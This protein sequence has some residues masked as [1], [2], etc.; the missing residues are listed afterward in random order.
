MRKRKDEQ[1]LTGSK[2]GLSRQEKKQKKLQDR[3]EQMRIKAL[4]NAY[5][6]GLKVQNKTHQLVRINGQTLE[7]VKA[8]LDAARDS[9]RDSGPAGGAH[10]GSEGASTPSG[11]CDDPQSTGRDYSPPPDDDTA[12]GAF[13]PMAAQSQPTRQCASD[14]Q[15]N[16][17]S[18]EEDE[19]SGDS[20]GEDDACPEM[21]SIGVSAYGVN[22]DDYAQMVRMTNDSQCDGSMFLTHAVED[23]TTSAIMCMPGRHM[24][25][26]GKL[27]WGVIYH[28]GFI[29]LPS[30]PDSTPVYF[31]D[32][33][34]KCIRA[35]M[36]AE[37]FLGYTTVTD[38][39]NPLRDGQVDSGSCE[40]ID[41]LQGIVKHSGMTATV[42]A[43]SV[44]Q[45]CK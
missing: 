43:E 20:S 25:K 38:Q 26:E 42:F 16:S 9:N 2:P 17:E 33:C 39:F 11:A 40:H 21:H 5:N 19:D 28:P 24:K 4:Q 41:A 44:R 13:S 22:E 14:A 1:N 35:R 6:T 30:N 45:T 12:E 8:A 36:Q 3:Q 18:E 10:D 15:N 32:C 29:I 34:P 7:Q 27:D 37:M 23:E 31:C